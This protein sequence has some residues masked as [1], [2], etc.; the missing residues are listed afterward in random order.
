MTNN[1]N[2]K[3]MNLPKFNETFLPILEVLKDG[4]I[5]K[6]RDL[7]RIVEERFY[8][9]LPAHLLEQTTKS[10]DRV[11]ENRIAWGKSN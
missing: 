5:I 6:G 1:T 4:K 2:G 9:S 8:S 3:S 10:G 11:I 7:I